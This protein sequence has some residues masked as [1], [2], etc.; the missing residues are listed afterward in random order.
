MPLQW[1]DAR[2]FPRPPRP[3]PAHIVVVRFCRLAAATLGE[4]SPGPSGAGKPAAGRCSGVLRDRTRRLFR[5]TDP[6]ARL[7]RGGLAQS[8][9]GLGRHPTAAFG[10]RV[11]TARG[12]G[13]RAHPQALWASRAAPVAAIPA[14]PV[15]GGYPARAGGDLRGTC[16]ES[17]QWLVSCAVFGEL[18]RSRPLSPFACAV[19]E[20]ARHDSAFFRANLAAQ[21]AGRIPRPH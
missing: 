19:A 17:R 16:T 21:R 12:L 4:D 15:R 5:H 10:I 9:A 14:R 20:W 18:D 1:A 6:A 11:D 3:S 2:Y 7:S 13:V 8:T